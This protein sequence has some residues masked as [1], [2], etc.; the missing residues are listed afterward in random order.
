MSRFLDLSSWPR[1]KHFDLF[2]QYE[3]PFFN[4][5]ANL[6][7]TALLDAVRV[8][9][10][11]SFFLSALYFSI[12]AANEIEP[13]RYRLRGD[14]ILVHDVVHPSSTVLRDD[15]TFGFAYFRFE[16][17]FDRFH[18]QGTHVIREVKETTAVDPHDDLDD[19]IHYSV[20]PWISFTSFAHARR[21]GTE[22]STPKIVFGK[23]FTEDGT[24][25]LPVSVDVHHA[26]M[27]GIHVGR[28]FDLLGTYLAA[29]GDYF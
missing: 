23:Y 8:E 16:Q 5:C 3:R 14:Q 11:K 26:L 2:R 20:I 19:Q 21:F 17:D 12:K 24:T 6:D 9:P 13:F 22:D 10:R 29:P 27:D 15:E 25:R 7:V 1:R 18:E 4:I 28:Y